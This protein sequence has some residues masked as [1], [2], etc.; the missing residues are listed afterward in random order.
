[1]QVSEGQIGSFDEK[2]R[3]VTC[4]IIYHVRY[5]SCPFLNLFWLTIVPT[6]TETIRTVHF[7]SND[8]RFFCHVFDDLFGL[9]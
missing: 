2:N 8:S 1:M 7:R 6:G 4:F 5:L 9:E 3:F